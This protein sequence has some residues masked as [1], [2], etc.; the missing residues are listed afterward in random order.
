[1]YGSRCK[2]IRVADVIEEITMFV[3]FADT[4]MATFMSPVSLQTLSDLETSLSDVETSV[5]DISLSEKEENTCE[6]EVRL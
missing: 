1:M 5:S 3:Y 2:I 6:G 4:K